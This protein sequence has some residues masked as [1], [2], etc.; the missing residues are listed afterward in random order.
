MVTGQPF[1]SA[2]GKELF[3][4]AAEELLQ[5]N[6]GGSLLLFFREM[7]VSRHRFLLLHGLLIR[8]LLLMIIRLVAHAIR[9]SVSRL[10]RLESM[11]IPAGLRGG[12][13]LSRKILPMWWSSLVAASMTD[14]SRNWSKRSRKNWAYSLP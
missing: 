6:G 4:A 8:Y 14:G 12:T 7:N 9:F 13:E 11:R 2:G 5:I 10:R 3:T 1:F